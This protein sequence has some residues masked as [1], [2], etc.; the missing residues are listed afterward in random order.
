MIQVSVIVPVHDP[1]S[2]IDDLIRSALEQSLPAAAYELIFVDDGSTDDTPARLDALAAAR[3]N[4]RVEHT[5]NSGWPG[6]PRNIGL[7]LARGDYVYFVDNDDWI[8][9]EALERLADRA[10]AD[11]ADVV[12]GKVVGHG[13]SVPRALFRRNRT[14]VTLDWPPLMTMLTPHKLFRRAFLAE[15]G[16]RFAEGRRRLED[17]L[18]VMHAY[19]HAQRISILADYPCYHWMKR[20]SNAS[21]AAFDPGGYF[22]N[23][24][25]VLDLVVEHTEPGPVRDQLLSHWYRGKMLKR[26]GGAALL[27]RDGERPEH[28]R[29][30]F[31]AIRELAHERYGDG[32]E[33][34]LPFHLRVRSRLLRAGD[35]DGLVE[36]ARFE[37]QLEARADAYLRPEASGLRVRAD[38]TLDGREQ[39]LRFERQGDR[40]HWVAPRILRDRLPADALDATEGFAASGVRLL[41]RSKADRA[42]FAQPVDA[43]V[44]LAREGVARMIGDAPLLPR[45]AAAGARLLPGDWELRVNPVV[46][47][48]TATVLARRRGE[49]TPLALEVKPSGRLVERR[50]PPLP[51]ALPIRVKRRV[52]RLVRG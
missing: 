19:L 51:P 12:V 3:E 36:L 42:E 4:V 43:E 17:H 45:R 7:D 30:V 52:K 13:K 50:P 15:H 26:V 41:L 47:G 33:A 10:R 37:A 11:E 35:Y 21:W 40:V 29:A 5:P 8:G 2:N 48:F 9:A 44:R 20:A 6:R 16:I 46:A 22:A 23:L 34:L 25:E 32:V 49:D 18:F 38:T 28:T 1:G 31:D 39:P 27:R 14:G 24:R